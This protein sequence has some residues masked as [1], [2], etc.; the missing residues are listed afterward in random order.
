MVDDDIAFT[1][2]LCD[3]L[4]RLGYEA[5][6]ANYL[7]DGLR[8]AEHQDI[9][10]VLLDVQMPDGNGLDFLPKF[11]N[12]G[13]SPEIIII[14]G[15]GD[16]DGAE[17][18]IRSGAWGYIEKPDVVREIKLNI[19]RV[20]AY[21][22]EKEKAR[23]KAIFL[24]K[25]NIIGNSP[26]LESCLNQI[27]SYAIS[28]INVLLKG[29]TGVG[30]ELFARAIHENSTRSRNNFVIV[31]CASLPETLAESILFG[32]EKGAFT[33][34]E[35]NY[36]GLLSQA[37]NG[38]LFLDEVGELNLDMQKKFL[39]ALQEHR[40]RPVGA[41]A[42]E[43]SNFRLIA[44][45]NRDLTRMAE[46]G[47]FREDLLFRLETAA[48]VLPP[49]RNRLGDIDALVVHYFKEITGRYGIDPKGFSPDFLLALRSYSWP[50]NVR[51]LINT[52]EVTINN[53]FHEPIVYAR[54]LPETIRV[55]SVRKTVAGDKSA[56]KAESGPPALLE[57]VDS[58]P[59]YREFRDNILHAAEQDYLLKLMKQARGSIKLACEIA[60]LGRTR[61]HNLMKKH[62]ISRFGTF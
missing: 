43:A 9:G 51:E 59:P 28:D 25:N 47:H 2:M 19:S 54:H 23:T 42:E 21:R 7:A 45:T 26:A 30:K 33:G 13:A 17:L 41:K 56:K 11:K 52:L 12:A 34:A 1:E 24:K 49:L 5:R 14:T 27:A 37:D 61:L 36:P 58:L 44:A 55:H 32:H 3:Q 6:R 57:A 38:T 16:A 31:D 60:G 39:R 22:Q 62:N 53:A 4:E 48:I 35:K 15:K 18:A 29:E 10:V 50:G 8:M 20:L 40:Y 46:T